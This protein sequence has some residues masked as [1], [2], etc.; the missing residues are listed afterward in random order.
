MLILASPGYTKTPYAPKKGFT[1]DIE[2]VPIVVPA[3]LYKV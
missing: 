1:L 3:V 2:L